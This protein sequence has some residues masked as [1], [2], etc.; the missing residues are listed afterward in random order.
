[1]SKP[2]K[3]FTL[4][5]NQ[6]TVHF[7]TEPRPPLL[8]RPRFGCLVPWWPPGAPLGSPRPTSIG[9]WSDTYQFGVITSENLFLSINLEGKKLLSF[10]RGTQWHHCEHLWVQT[11][12]LGSASHLISH[13]FHM[14]DFWN[15]TQ[16]NTQK[17][18]LSNSPKDH[19]KS[20][21]V[22]KRN[23]THWFLTLSQT[24]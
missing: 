15:K 4:G 1:M 2:P 19:R 9:C 23:P 22:F 3:C 6:N 20:V 5:R 11:F 18:K 14:R 12:K 24:Y 16:A 17:S 8:I 21:S 7:E 13:S 10:S